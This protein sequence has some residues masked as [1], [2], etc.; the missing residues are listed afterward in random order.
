M[1][2]IRS[3]LAVLLVAWSTLAA[4]G[5]EVFSFDDPT[6]E[7]RFNRLTD[8]LRCLV[9]QNQSLSESNA[10]LA[11]DLRH[12]VY[13]MI[14]SGASDEQIVDFMVARYGDFVRYRPPVKP[15]TYAL[16]AGPFVVLAL[17]L[18]VLARALRRQQD[19][20]ATQLSEQDRA[21]A[22]RLLEDADPGERP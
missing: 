11:K 18:W 19:Q 10:E 17:G 12:E 22:R 13:G 5:I 8:E 20:A 2:N 16:W 15:T 6:Q 4:G 7:E 21:R 9:C 1:R 3:A 14:R